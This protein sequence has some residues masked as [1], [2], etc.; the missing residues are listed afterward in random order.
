MNAQLDN[1]LT[2]ALAVSRVAKKYA[3]V[4]TGISS[5]KKAFEDHD[6][7]V[8]TIQETRLQT[9]K[10]AK[11]HTEKKDNIRIQLAQLAVEMASAIS[12]MAHDTNNAP[13]KAQVDYSPSDFDHVRAGLLLDRARLVYTKAMENLNALKQGYA[14][15]EEAVAELKRLIDTFNELD[16][17]PL[18]ARSERKDENAELRKEFKE[19]DLLYENRLDKLMKSLE[20]SQPTF[21]S[22]YRNAHNIINLGVR[23][24]EEEEGE[25]QEAKK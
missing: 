19:L 9:E 2:S 12:V 16:P 7:L 17:A 24:E 6:A 18:N 21:F 15:T 1:K 11:G 14:V 20:T 23:D 10:S 8:E 4:I 25:N 5:L 13:L 22:A 3:E